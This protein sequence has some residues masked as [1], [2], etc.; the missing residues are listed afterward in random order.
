MRCGELFRVPMPSGRDPKRNR[1]FVIVSR[2]MLIDSRFS[3]VIC[4][5]VYSHHDGLETQV[6]VGID[7]GLKHES[8]IH[9]DEL[10]SLPKSLLT[11]YVGTLSSDK[12]KEL[13]QALQAALELD[14]E[15]EDE[16]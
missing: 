1:V 13:K 2:Q 14:E 10:V 9:C 3:S 5:P 6:R 8:S 4:A 16:T 7:E 11:N 12:I 15:V